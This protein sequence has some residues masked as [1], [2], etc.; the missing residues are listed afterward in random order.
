[1]FLFVTLWSVL[2]CVQPASS[3]AANSKDNNNQKVSGSYQRYGDIS[4]R[5]SAGPKLFQMSTAS[6][7]LLSSTI[8]ER[9][10]S[11]YFNPEY[12]YY[13]GEK[14]SIFANI[15]FVVD[16]DLLVGTTVGFGVGVGL[17]YHIIPYL[18]IDL[19]TNIS[20]V[21]ES[22]FR[23]EF[24]GLALGLG[25]SIPLSSQ[26]R[27]LLIGQVPFNFIDGFVLSVRGF[28]GF[29]SFF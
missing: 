23:L 11:L 26:V 8:G 4:F 20:F 28:L 12:S 21:R 13:F 9:T 2:L 24:G 18:Y 14:F 19:E 5:F 6:G 25:F 27:L 3:L 22:F 29:E 16:V 17:R 15:P 1:M 10:F 7:E